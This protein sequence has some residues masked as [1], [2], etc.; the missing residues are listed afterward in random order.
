MCSL[1][2][3]QF[4]PLRLTIQ[5]AF[6]FFQNYALFSTYFLSFSKH[7][8]AERWHPHVVPLFCLK[9]RKL[10]TMIQ[11]VFLTHFQTSPGFYVSAVQVFRKH[12]EKRRNCF[13]LAIRS[14]FSFSHSV[15]HKF[16]ELSAIFIKLEIVICKHFEFGRV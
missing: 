13:I 6:F 15:F 3:E 16:G 11:R 12:C 5:N 2:T 9:F 8:T 14:N 4:I 7:P 10:L 1:S